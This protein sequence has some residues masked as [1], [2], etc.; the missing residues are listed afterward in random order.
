MDNTVG[1]L[2][3][4]LINPEDT[5]ILGLWDADKYL[6]TSSV[7]LSNTDPILIS[8][9]ARF[10]LSRFSTDRIRLRIYGDCEKNFLPEIKKS[11]LSSFSNKKVAFHL[12]VNSRSL[13]REFIWALNNRHTMIKENLLPYIAGRFDGDGSISKGIRRY[14]RISYGSLEDAEKDLSLLSNYKVKMY[15]YKQA[16][17]YCLYFSEKNLDPLLM[18]LKSYSTKLQ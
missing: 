9:F 7:G 5:Y 17:T 14:F 10:L 12:Y 11:F 1:S 16:H 6:R 18:G 2:S 8:R 13:V 3:S 15:Y 4:L